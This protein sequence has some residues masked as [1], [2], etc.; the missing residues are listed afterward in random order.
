MKDL[1][2]RIQKQQ[3]EEE[4]RKRLKRERKKEK[5]VNS[6]FSQVLHITF[7]NPNVIIPR[8][9]SSCILQLTISYI[10]IYEKPLCLFQLMSLY[11]QNEK[12]GFGVLYLCHYIV[13][14]YFVFEETK[15]GTMVNILCYIMEGNL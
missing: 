1:D 9:R 2:E 7:G 15:A 10:Y 11:A 13:V 3:E 6:L 4:E 14:P 5:K 8:A 12:V